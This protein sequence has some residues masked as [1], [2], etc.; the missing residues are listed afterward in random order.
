MLIEDNRQTGAEPED[1]QEQQLH[2]VVDHTGKTSDLSPIKDWKGDTLCVL[3][4]THIK[5]QI[6]TRKYN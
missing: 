6:R 5:E 1:R 3:R 4:Y 2:V